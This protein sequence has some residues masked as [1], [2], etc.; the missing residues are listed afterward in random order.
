MLSALPKPFTKED[1]EKLPLVVYRSIRPLYAAP[2]YHD[3]VDLLLKEPKNVESLT[4]CNRLELFK[5]IAKIIV[6]TDIESAVLMLDE[7]PRRRAKVRTMVTKSFSESWLYNWMAHAACDRLL[8]AS[9]PWEALL[10]LR[11]KTYQSSKK[12][13]KGII[14]KFRAEH[15]NWA[16]A[17]NGYINRCPPTSRDSSASSGGSVRPVTPTSRSTTPRQVES[18]RQ[19]SSLSTSDVM[20]HDHS[21]TCSAMSTI[22]AESLRPPN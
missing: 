12:P 2:C 1:R 11:K 7:D 22:P 16:G 9:K 20:C 4:R 14:K 10:G 21:A 15:L 17:W 18:S 6:T 13:T 3:D 19:C 5:G 8:A